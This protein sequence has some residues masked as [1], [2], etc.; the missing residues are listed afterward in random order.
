MKDNVHR[1]HVN[2]NKIKKNR[3]ILTTFLRQYSLLGQGNNR[4]SRK[5]ENLLW[6]R[7]FEELICNLTIWEGC[8]QFGGG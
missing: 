3:N 7:K 6:M 2:S 1:V 5:E 8:H 4:R